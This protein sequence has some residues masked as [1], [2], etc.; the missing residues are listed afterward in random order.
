[1]APHIHRPQEDAE[2]D[3]ILRMAPGPVLAYFTGTWP[4]ALEACRA[5]DALVAEAVEEFGPRLTAVRTDMTRCP[6]TT[7]RF[8]VTGAPTAVV[9]AEGEAVAHAAGPLSRT[10]LRALL[11]AHL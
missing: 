10:E 6:A 4:K 7:R 3:F 1:M 8:G 2:F 5:M 9:V 11:E